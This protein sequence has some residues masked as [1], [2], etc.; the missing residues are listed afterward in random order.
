[1][2][3]FKKFICKLLTLAACLLLGLNASAEQYN[4]TSTISFDTEHIRCLPVGEVS[5]WIYITLTRN[6]STDNFTNIQFQMDMPEGLQVLGVTNTDT[7]A[8]DCLS[9]RGSNKPDDGGYFVLLLNVM[10]DGNQIKITKNPFILCRMKLKKTGDLPPD[11][12]ISI[13]NMRYTDSN[14]G[15]W[16]AQDHTISF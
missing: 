11:A 7:D 3:P 8:Y 1:M 10:S 12:K 13:T 9:V 14:D 2:M 5:D 6:D 4:C 15:S 16:T